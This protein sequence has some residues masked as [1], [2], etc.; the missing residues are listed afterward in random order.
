V[1]LEKDQVNSIDDLAE[2]VYQYFEAK[3]A[4]RE[5]ALQ[6]TRVAIRKC[7]ASIRSVHRGELEK[8]EM[9]ME[10][11]GTALA[12]IGELLQDHPDVRYAGFVSTAEQEYAEAVFLY[13]IITQR[14][15]PSPEDIGVEMANY[16]AGLGDVTGE[17]R[18]HVLDLIRQG[19]AEEGEP[20]LQ[21]ME[22]IY[23]LLMLFDY[24]DAIT[25]GLRRKG[26]M[27]RSIL[28]RTRGD[29]TNAMGQRSLAKK[30]QDLEHKLKEAGFNP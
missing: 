26:D 27:A 10:E 12:K 1:S 5:M 18:R 21:A 7:G 29:L 20:F 15:T 25:G 9:L 28:E 14:K 17:L 3:D 8:A 30:L 4:A 6:L 2:E 23:H 19:R 24:P 13:A 11:A 22:D 16:L